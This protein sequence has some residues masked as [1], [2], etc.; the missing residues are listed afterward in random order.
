MKRITHLPLLLVL[1]LFF[2]PLTTSYSQG[3]PYDELMEWYS[4]LNRFINQLVEPYATT[5]TIKVE[6]VKENG[7]QISIYLNDAAVNVPYREELLEAIYGEIRRLLPEEKKEYRVTVYCDKKPIEYYV[8]EREK[9]RLRPTR[10]RWGEKMKKATSQPPLVRQ[11]GTPYSITNGLQNRHIALWQSHGYYYDK[12]GKWKWQR[13]VL[14]GT[15]EDLYTQSYVLPYLVPMLENA[16]AVVML[17]RERDLNKVEYI[18]DNDGGELVKGVYQEQ[19]GKNKWQTGAGTAFAYK[20]ERY[21]N[22]QNP[23]TDGTYRVAKTRKRDNLSRAVWTPHITRKGEYAVYVSYQSL[24]N[25]APD[26]VYS[27]HHLGGVTSFEVNQKMGGGTWIYLGTFP[28]APAK[29]GVEQSFITLT[30]QSSHSGTVVTAD[31]VKI[32]GGMGNVERG[33]TKTVYRRRR[34]RSVPVEYT[35]SGKPRYAEAARYWMQWAGVPDSTYNYYKGKNDYTDDYRQR[36]HWVN[37]ISGGSVSNP[38]QKGLGVP[39]DLAFAFH[40][41]AGVKEGEQLVGTLTIFNTKHGVGAFA[42]GVSRTASRDLADIVQTSIVN[43]IRRTYRADWVRRGM[44]NKNYSEATWPKVPVMLLEMLSHQNKADMQYGLD[45][46][47]QFTVSRAIY[48][49]ILRYLSY[50]YDY[51]YVV[52]PLPPSQLIVEPWGENQVRL[53]WQPT[54]DQLEKSASPNHYMI[55]TRVGE[56]GFDNGV[57]TKEKDVILPVKPGEIYSFKVTGVNSG[58]E[59]FPSE[60]VSIGLVPNAIASVLV[61]NAFDRLSGPDFFGDNDGGVPYIKAITA[62]EHVAGNTFDFAQIHGKAVMA[63]G[64]SFATASGSVIEANPDILKGYSMVDVMLGKQ[65]QSMVGTP[66]D[67]QVRYKGLTRNLQFALESYMMNGGKVIL[68]GSYLLSDI[69]ASQVTDTNE[70]DQLFVREVLTMK[71]PSGPAPVQNIVKVIGENEHGEERMYDV[72]FSWRPNPDT[73]YVDRADPLV[74]LN[75]GKIFM[76]AEHGSPLGVM[77]E[78]PFPMVL[79]TIPLEVIEK[80]EDRV[81]LMNMYL[82][83]LMSKK[84]HL[85]Y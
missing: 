23:F 83:F 25:S 78:Q 63:S 30:N 66:K 73:Y 20:R 56:G 26:A 13:P 10:A 15:V 85:P 84:G 43:D 67:R 62:T 55:Y 33:G 12:A 42:N 60:V 53:S 3:V 68:T 65:R 6:E 40:S 36:G 29:D 22:G 4:P 18:I 19:N 45:P 14:F 21:R 69:T 16:G 46:T 2:A 48:K 24:P 77:I 81:W 1:T 72:P 79:S 38:G 35:T 80:E 50:E 39:I 58:G 75:A 64:C 54:Q 47:F 31:A 34:R 44:W 27:V 32:G 61:V 5:G 51:P 76:M 9:K 8:P 17:P 82:R 70:D 41:D 28:F 49:G 57:I 11:M 52:Q 74:P 71:E 37:Y 59:S 7:R